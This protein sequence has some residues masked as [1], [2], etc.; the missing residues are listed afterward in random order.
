MI[1]IIKLSKQFDQKD[2]LCDINLDLPS[3]GLIAICGPSGCGKTTFLNCLSGL[4]NY[5]GNIVIDG[6]DIAN[7]SDEEMSL[8]RLKNYGFIFQDFKLFEND[9]LKDNIFLT[10]DLT[11]SG[12][13][14][15]KT[16]KYRDVVDAVD[17]KRKEKSLVKNLSGGEKQRVAI[18]RAIIHEPKII[19]ADE[20]TGNL[21]E[22]NTLEIF[23]ILKHISQ[24]TLVIVVSHDR[25]TV[26]S[27]AD[28]V[29]VIEEG[30]IVDDY[31]TL[32]K[33]KPS[34]FTICENEQKEGNNRLPFSFLYRHTKASL[35][36]KKWRTM[37]C[38]AITSLG[39]VGV[40]LSFNLSSIISQNIK[41]AYSSIIDESAIAIGVK[42]MDQGI[43]TLSSISEEETEQIKNENSEYIADMGVLYHN[44]FS[45]FFKTL[46]VISISDGNYNYPIEGL[47]VENVNE[48]E[49]LDEIDVDTILPNSI[50]QLEN[51]EVVIG[52][53]NQQI[54]DICYRLRITKN[55]QSLSNY[56][57]THTVY[58][59]LMVENSDWNYSNDF[60]L[61]LKGFF[62]SKTP[63]I[64]HS[65]HLWNKYIFEE[66]FDLPTKD[67]GEFNNYPYEL[68][69]IPYLKCNSKKD[70]F[71]KLVL[72]NKEYSEY[73]FEIGSQNYFPRLYKNMSCIDA[74]RILLFRTTSSYI[75]TSYCNYF[76]DISNAL[77]NPIF[78]TRGGYSIYPSSFLSGFSRLNLFASDEEL[79]DDAIDINSHIRLE[80][81][82]SIQNPKG[83]LSGHYSKKPSNN[84]RFAPIN[85]KLLIGNNPE[86]LD[87]IVVSSSMAKSIF[88]TIDV[89]G[90]SLSCSFCVRET[91]DQKGFI[92]RT[93]SNLQLTIT[94]VIDSSQLC[95]YHYS[96]W[97]I[98]FYQCRLGI[99]ITELLPFLVSFSV[100]ESKKSISA[101]SLQKAFPTYEIMDPFSKVQTSINDVCSFLKIV[102][103]FLSLIALIISFLLLCSCNSLHAF[104]SRREIGLARCI[105]VSKKES[106]KFVYAH[107]LFLSLR[108]F[109]FS[110]MEL[111][112]VSVVMSYAIS[113]NV[114]SGFV[115]TQ[116]VFSYV[117]MLLISLGVALLTA[118]VVTNKYCK[119]PPLDSLK[120]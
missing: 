78:C 103:L 108:S 39:L 87:E 72:D 66:L 104:E 69:K 95:I 88:S 48:F 100:K 59:S 58:L 77:M 42:N 120:R 67:S 113:K 118:V 28:R 12:S 94:G 41:N 10:L 116:N 13:K 110:T 1:K 38:T 119:I 18:A 22:K 33:K 27:F 29:I 45:S 7:Y 89:V 26:D 50:E 6:Q 60:S 43:N 14:K 19:L 55:A 117:L 49:W 92:N 102:V 96:H 30:K 73:I 52:L 111:F 86:S 105:G 56:L 53:T 51:N 8:F 64:Y 68:F 93:F 112:F 115:V 21:D 25:D 24:K 62:L 20:P 63:C 79:L 31:Q 35:K 36:N 84:V 109:F 71:L 107:S 37:I 9:S 65:N 46:N 81:N 3:K 101:N 57:K 98:N 15:R 90:K 70:D 75:P 11:N 4:I 34:I 23:Q 54:Q 106:K 82:E 74:N 97:T 83:V 114:D 16:Q 32:R 91:I 99:S 80:D 85:S 5:S 2:V 44:D 40:G 61:S 76:I 47:S 17:L